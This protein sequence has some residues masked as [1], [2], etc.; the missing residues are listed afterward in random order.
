MTERRK[1]IID[2]INNNDI[3]LDIGCDMAILGEEL[4]KKGIH[5][6]ASDIRES[7][8]IKAKKRIEKLNLSEYITFY[9]SDGFKNIKSH[10]DTV[11]ISGMG[12][13]NIIK[14]LSLINNK[15]KKIIIVSNNNFHIIR[16]E[17]MKLNYKIK[18]EEI[19]K[20]KNKFYNLI[21]YTYGNEK[22]NTEEIYFGKNHKNKILLHEI[23]NRYLKELEQ[24]YKY[25]KKEIIKKL[26]NILIEYK[27]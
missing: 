25:N 5:S 2:R 7:I 23:N 17:M 20:E 13:N 4:A 16:E 27:Y 14:I 3:V 19:I 26:L 18:E 9:T 1:A 24:I 8:I 10:Y 11:V 21:L 22:L 12:A 15:I 6:I